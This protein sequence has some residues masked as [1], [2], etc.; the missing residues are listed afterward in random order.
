MKFHLPSINQFSG[1][2]LLL[3]S[4]KIFKVFWDFF[5]PKKKN[6]EMK[7]DL[8]EESQSHDVQGDS[9]LA[10][11]IDIDR[12]GFLKVFCQGSSNYTSLGDQT[13]QMYGNLGRFYLQ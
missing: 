5:P 11:K 8:K 4:F 10:K 2:N 6:R 12:I 7:K 13:M 3:V 9:W 1:V